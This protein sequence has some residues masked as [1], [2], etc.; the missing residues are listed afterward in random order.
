[1]LPITIILT[2]EYSDWEI[3]PLI[4]TGRAF[5]GAAFRFV[6]PTGGPL[7][8]VGGLP[9]AATERLKPLEQGV[10]VLCGGPAWESAE[11]PDIGGLLRQSLDHGAILAAICGGTAALARAGLLDDVRHTSNGPGYLDQL[12]PSYRGAVH[13]VDQPQA[14]RDGAIITAPAPA[15]ASF[16]R[17]VLAA[18]GLAAEA[19][20]QVT[21][22][23]ALEHRA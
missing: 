6:S 19:A 11:A 16:A 23:L 21:Q 17:E 15:P 18:A 20:A 13:Y 5:F 14:L 4:G 9:I 1:M 2:P 7:A 3:A 12:V 10:L 22:M 8:S